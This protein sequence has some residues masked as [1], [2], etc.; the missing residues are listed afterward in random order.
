MS[1]AGILLMIA[2]GTFHFD[3][4]SSYHLPKSVQA[5][6]IPAPNRIKIICVNA[7]LD[8]VGRDFNFGRASV[9]GPVGYSHR[10]Y[11]KPTIRNTRF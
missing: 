11:D 6:I 7:G 10:F 4:N 3:V 9:F 2:P 8:H 1:L 5:G